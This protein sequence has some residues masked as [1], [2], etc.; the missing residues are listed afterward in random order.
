MIMPAQY[1]DS[2]Q[3]L[4]NALEKLPIESSAVDLKVK[5]I[6]GTRDVLKCYGYDAGA[7]LFVEIMM[8]MFG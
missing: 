2:M 4:L 1:E 3:E 8:K 7:D 6:N 5:A